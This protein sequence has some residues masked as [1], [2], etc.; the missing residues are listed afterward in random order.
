MRQTDSLCPEFC[1][2]YI[3]YHITIIQAIKLQFENNRNYNFHG[4]VQI[5]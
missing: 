5:K 2:S 1:K 4:N 3:S